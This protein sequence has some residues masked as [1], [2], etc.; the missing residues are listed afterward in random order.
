[1][2]QFQLLLY[3]LLSCIFALGQSDIERLEKEV[4][5]SKGIE[6]LELR[7]QLA[8]ALLPVDPVRSVSIGEYVLVQT[9]A[10]LN[11]DRTP[12]ILGIE[13]E[14]FYVVG[15]GH[16]EQG[17]AKKA[18][19]SYRRCL[20]LA[21][22]LRNT[23]LSAKADAR[24][25]ELDSLQAKEEKKS[26]EDSESSSINDL[27]KSLVEK[28][29]DGSNALGEKA[30]E[31]NLN[32]LENMAR[33]N[34]EEGDFGRAA[35]LYEK[36]IKFLREKND[37]SALAERYTKIGSMFQQAGEF[38]ISMDYYDRALSYRNG[39]GDTAGANAS[40]AGIESVLQ[41]LNVS[42]EE[43]QL[44]NTEKGSSGQKYLELADD[45]AEQGD[46]E[47]SL[48]YYK[49]FTELQAEMGLKEADRQSELLEAQKLM[50][51]RT[52]EVEALKQQKRA[53][54]LDLREKELSIDRFKLIRN[55][56]LVG[57]V[58]LIGL[59]F[60]LYVLFSTKKKSE[61]Q[62]RETYEQLDEAHSELKSAQTRLV[63][64]EKMASLGQLT[65][66]I[67]HE[68]NNPINFVSANVGPL[69][70][71]LDEL[72][73][74]LTAYTGLHSQS[75]LEN[76]L[77]EI[78]QLRQKVDPDFLYVE[79]ETL[80]NGIREGANRTKEIVAGLRHFSRVDEG[81]SKPADLN[82]G[83][84][85]TLTL[86]QNNLKSK[87]KVVTELG[88]IPL[89]VCHPGKINQVFMNLISNAIQAM[90]EEGTMTIMSQQKDKM[91]LVT[92]SDTGKGMDEATRS[93]IFEP[94]FTTKDVGEGTGLGLS[95]SY[96]IIESHGG[97]IKVESELGKGST[98]EVRLPV[99][100]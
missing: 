71:D 50:D 28:I 91:V 58:L 47:K 90:G 20:R 80:L 30:K 51:Q 14:A 40:L 34:E 19:R 89:V 39:L 23:D 100:A 26:K 7:L 79:I 53:Q 59:A 99:L 49:L 77:K 76:R 3:L 46:Y 2:K 66:G 72:K 95:I 60:A 68:I 42:S 6:K 97:S 13:A 24:L 54:Q 92:I 16:L 75:E 69:K 12:K 82:E 81:E 44:T 35:V 67:A 17:N 41:D 31:L 85:S 48:E 96:G 63:E 83:L 74:L 11:P 4:E 64:S 33:T 43:S 22:D 55:F 56:L 38:G 27:T 45:A 98:F 37:S 36:T 86:L 73:Q 5:A 29:S 61:R 9:Q 52:A 25:L 93:R 18:G 62:L 1:M 88:E 87:I 10:R 57:L 94:F 70:R 32:T 15:E 21:E 8:T 78:N 65:A 84:T